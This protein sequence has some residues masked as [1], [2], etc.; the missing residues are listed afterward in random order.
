M[1]PVG[2]EYRAIEAL[3][4]GGDRRGAELGPLLI[5]CALLLLSGKLIPSAKAAGG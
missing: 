2:V 4:S 3:G 1:L 5:A